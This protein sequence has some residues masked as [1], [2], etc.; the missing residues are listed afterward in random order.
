MIQ[1]SVIILQ[2]INLYGTGLSLKFYVLKFFRC[3][4][5]MIRWK[6]RNNMVPEVTCLDFN[7]SIFI[8]DVIYLSFL[9][10]PDHWENTIVI[11]KI[12]HIVD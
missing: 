1:I 10:P 3:D 2:R 7:C 11:D 4:Q 12:H 5:I 6:H 8:G 9:I